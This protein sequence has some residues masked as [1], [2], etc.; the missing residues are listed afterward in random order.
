MKGGV[1][2]ST[3]KE[4]RKACRKW[5]KVMRLQDWDIVC[6]IQRTK[7]MNMEN[8]EG[9]CTWNVMNKTAVIRIL[10]PVDYP[11]N[12][13]EQNMEETLVHELMHLHSAPFDDFKMGTAKNDALEQMIVT[14][15]Q[16]L[17]NSKK[18][19]G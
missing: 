19:G 10:D 4:L 15:S 12:E 11:D 5:Q 18:K 2:Y 8:V 7:G 6:K 1:I 3:D 16:A 17:I 13:W 9:S 14:L